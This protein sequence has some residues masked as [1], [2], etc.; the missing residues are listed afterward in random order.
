MLDLLSS[1]LVIGII[2][3]VIG[4]VA[5]FMFSGGNPQVHV[6]PEPAPKPTKPKPKGPFTVEEVAK[7]NKNND[8]WIIINGKVYDVS[9]FYLEHPGN[10]RD[11]LRF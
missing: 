1:P 4:I 10:A 7:H 5:Y 9:D 8:Y 3:G 2:L 11:L 6:E